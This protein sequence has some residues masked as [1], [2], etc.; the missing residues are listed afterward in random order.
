MKNIVKSYIRI[1]ISEFI[2]ELLIVYF[3][4][5]IRNHVQWRIFWN[6]GFFLYNELTYE[7]MAYF[8]DMKTKLSSLIWIEFLIYFWV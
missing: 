3:K 7:F 5:L 2:W 1:H 4:L 6:D 8:M